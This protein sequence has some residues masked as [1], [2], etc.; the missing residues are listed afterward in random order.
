MVSDKNF[1][2]CSAK[3]FTG[4]T[5]HPWAE[6]V[7]VRDGVIAAFGSNAEV[8]AALPGTRDLGLSGALVVPGV[9]DAH[10]HFANLGLSFQMADLRNLKSLEACRAKIK[11]AAADLKPGQ[12]LMGRN[13]NHTFWSEARE[14]LKTDLDDLLPNNPAVMIR[15]CG[16]SQWV[17]SK[18]LE[19]MGIT[20]DTPNPPGGQY[21]R[22]TSGK[23]TGMLREAQKIVRKFVPEPTLNELKTAILSAQKLALQNGLTGVHTCESLTEWKAFAA[24]EA[25]G[26]L[27]L[28]VHHLLQPENLDDAEAMGLKPGRGSNRLWVG[29]LKLFADGSLGT[30]TALLCED[31]SDELGYRGLPFLD[32]S[33]LNEKV[34]DGYRRGFDVAIHAIGDLAGHNALNAIA[35][36]RRL[37]AGVRRDR[38]EHVQLCCQEDLARYKEMDVTASIQPIFVATDWSI[39]AQRWG[40]KRCE[41]AY[42]W[43]SIIDQG[44]RVQ[45]GSDSPVE[46][47]PPIYGLQAAVLRQ[48]QDLRPQGGWRPQERLSLAQS[49]AGFSA[50]AAWT[51]RKEKC[52]GS[53]KPGN[54]ADLTV[55]EKDLT[56]VPPEEWLA[57]EPLLT[58]IGGEIVFS[59]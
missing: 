10:C 14:P 18:A 13:W 55:Y 34:A 37:H 23:P 15:V 22:D 48:T 1:T 50:T 52:L 24:L 17:N 32:V 47:I 16:H 38:I 12:W 2:I 25:E 58:V 49:L 4:L 41:R 33:E 31:Y 20:A 51:S 11:K 30:G 29:H 35:N 56:Q 36:G 53:L 57:V 59:K 42:A 26:K 7:G 39:A 46:P 44:I 3:I 43:K 5:E 45:F 28:R 19:I 54:W 8:K 21:D 27:K 9:V 6:A 40:T